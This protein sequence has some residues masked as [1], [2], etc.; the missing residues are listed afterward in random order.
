MNLIYINSRVDLTAYEKQLGI[1]FC[2]EFTNYQTI[3]QQLWY[4]Q[5]FPHNRSG[6]DPIWSLQTPKKYQLCLP[7][8]CHNK[9]F[10]DITDQRAIELINRCQQKNQ[11]M[12]ITWSGGIDSTL[13]VAALFK[14]A[15][16][17]YLKQITVLMNNSSYYENP[18]FFDRI[19]SPYFSYN[20]IDHAI[21]HWK[22]SVVVSGQPADQMW[23]HADIV[24]LENRFPGAGD[25]DPHTDPDLLL[26]FLS[27]KSNKNHAEWFYWLVLNTAAEAKI[28]IVSY[29]DFFW[30]ANFNFYTVGNCLKS[31]LAEAECFNNEQFLLYQQNYIPWFL[32]DDYQ[33]WSIHNNNTG[34]KML[35]GL[36]SYKLVA[37]K[38]I[39]EVDNNQYYYHYKYKTGSPNQHLFAQKK[40]TEDKI[41][42]VFA[43]YDD[44]SAVMSDD[45]KSIGQLILNNINLYH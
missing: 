12:F 35:Q 13:I 42:K 18:V 25:I 41:K 2:Q 33:F 31:Y 9:T 30:W 1:Q 16:R 36:G 38:Y 26:D 20:N 3:S 8:F 40:T 44:G 22:D 29:R 17:E 21:C 15:D 43:L 39:L 5:H 24:K 32:T 14:H 27:K 28:S 34:V 10:E 7:S 45:S 6:V 19:I 23:I 4:E 11:P 37:K